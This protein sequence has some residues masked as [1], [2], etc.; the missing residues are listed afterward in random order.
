MHVDFN[1]I[2]CY[3]LHCIDC[4]LL[5]ELHIQH[6]ICFPV[7]P[8]CHHVQ[9]KHQLCVRS[10]RA[11]PV[12][13]WWHDDMI[14]DIVLFRSIGFHML[15]RHDF[16][17][18]QRKPEIPWKYRF[19]KQ[20]RVPRKNQCLY[21]LA[22]GVHGSICRSLTS[23]SEGRGR[24]IPDCCQGRVAWNLKSL[25]WNKPSISKLWG[26][27]PWLKKNHNYIAV[28]SKLLGKGEPCNACEKKSGALPWKPEISS[29]RFWG[30]QMCLECR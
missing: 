12:S 2:W 22:T 1:F 17:L 25:S 23:L 20:R 14:R 15:S 30:W 9:P 16:F 26:N 18:F 5:F 6:I 27:K 10:Q 19:G 7:I 3:M 29:M 4:I 21:G 8:Q 13:L 24:F 28:I 11:Y